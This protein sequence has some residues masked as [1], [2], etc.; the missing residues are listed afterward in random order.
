MAKKPRVWTPPKTSL[1]ALKE[2]SLRHSMEKQQLLEEIMLESR[3]KNDKLMHKDII[4]SQLPIEFDG[5][6]FSEIIEK[7]VVKGEE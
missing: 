1:R 7:E 6:R 5:T 2:M 4:E 3:D